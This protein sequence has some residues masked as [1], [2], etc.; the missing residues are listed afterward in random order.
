MFLITTYYILQSL[1]HYLIKFSQYS[2]CLYSQTEWKSLRLKQYSISV[3]TEVNYSFW[4]NEWAMTDLLISHLRMLKMQQKHSIT[5]FRDI[6]SLWVMT[7]K[8]TMTVTTMTL[9]IRILK[10]S[11]KLHHRERV[12]SQY[13]LRD[14]YIWAECW[15]S[16]LSIDCLSW[17]L[18]IKWEVLIMKILFLNEAL[19]WF[20]YDYKLYFKFC[21]SS[22]LLVSHLVSTLST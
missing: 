16:E 13:W 5:T 17:V 11:Q 2:I 1:I 4:F 22:F 9:C 21:F 6:Q 10:A 8:L 19:V 7:S 20:T 3:C 12:L 14:T 18:M 15:L